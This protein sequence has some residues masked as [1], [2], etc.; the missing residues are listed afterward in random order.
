ME[1]REYGEIYCNSAIE[2]APLEPLRYFSIGPFGLLQYFS[3]IA[4][5]RCTIFPFRRVMAVQRTLC[6]PMWW[7]ESTVTVAKLCRDDDNRASL[8]C[9]YAIT[10]PSKTRERYCHVIKPN[11]LQAVEA[12]VWQPAC[13]VHC[14]RHD[15]LSPSV[16]RS[17][18]RTPDY[19]RS[20]NNGDETKRFNKTRYSWDAI[21]IEIT[22]DKWVFANDLQRFN[23]WTNIC[24]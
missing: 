8:T 7:R 11:V 20:I 16:S 2:I 6:S 13:V 3:L 19:C 14:L 15:S 4:E 24:A 9:S 22:R 23:V 5:R 18:H 1:N 17:V 12:V 21:D 10:Q